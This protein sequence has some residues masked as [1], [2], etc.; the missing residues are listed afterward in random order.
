M[1]KY[2]GAKFDGG[3]G[4]W[5]MGEGVVEEV[6]LEVVPSL[7]TYR[8]R[9]TGFGSQRHRLIPN[10]TTKIA[11]LTGLKGAMIARQ[12]F[13]LNSPLWLIFP[14]DFGSKYIE[15]SIRNRITNTTTHTPCPSIYRSPPS[16]RFPTLLLG[17]NDT[18]KRQLRQSPCKQQNKLQIYHIG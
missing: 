2:R 9:V 15:Q 1:V 11:K 6:T 16:G 17:L 5:W 10:A 7:P 18:Y 3:V 8:G 14:R 12:Y 13:I 4:R